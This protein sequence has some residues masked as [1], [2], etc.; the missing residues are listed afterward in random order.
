MAVRYMKTK[1]NIHVG[2]NPGE[3]YLAKI[4]FNDTITIEKLS[5]LIAESSSYNEGDV[6]N[7]LILL[8]KK[9]S[10]LVMEGHPVDFGK[11]G[12]FYPRF[13]AKAME[14]YDEVTSETIKNFTIRFLPSTLLRSQLKNAK[15]E[16]HEVEI[17]SYVP[18]PTPPTP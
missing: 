14:T 2:Y 18:K 10:W 3:K 9:L 12:R 1:R 5:E 8:E 6:Y 16:F 15:F 4:I 7:M 11:F 17:K 13:D